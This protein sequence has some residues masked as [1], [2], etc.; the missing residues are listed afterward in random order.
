MQID[1]VKNVVYESFLEHP[2]YFYE[3]IL[4]NKCAAVENLEL[5]PLISFEEEQKILSSVGEVDYRSTRSLK[6]VVDAVY[7]CLGSQRPKIIHGHSDHIHKG[8][9]K[10]Y[11][12]DYNELSNKN[13]IFSHWHVDESPLGDVSSSIPFFISMHMRNFKCSSE[14]GKTIFVDREKMLKDMDKDFLKKVSKFHIVSIPKSNFDPEEIDGSHPTLKQLLELNYFCDSNGR[15]GS[16]RTFP[17]VSTHII[18]GKQSLTV[19]ATSQF[20]FLLCDDEGLRNDYFEYID[21]YLLDENN[22]TEFSWSENDFLIWDNS[23][24]IHSFSAGW[25]EDERSFDRSNIGEVD[26][27]FDSNNFLE[28]KNPL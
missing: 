19:H 14:Y 23:N 28:N 26:V 6:G 27:F 13:F 2:E 20:N 12:K 7:S 15:V 9:K 8:A 21:S 4:E 11:G 1:K 16:M 22:W 10:V 17:S 3:I 5:E 25:S 18:T 24:L